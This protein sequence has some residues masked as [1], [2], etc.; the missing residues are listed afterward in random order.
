MTLKVSKEKIGTE[1][2]FRV[3]DHAENPVLVLSFDRF[4]SG[5]EMREAVNKW[6]KAYG[7]ALED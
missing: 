6:A 7:A 4:K 3:T 5:A 1:M 2:A